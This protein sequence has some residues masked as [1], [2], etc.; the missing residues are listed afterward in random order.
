[1][2]TINRVF[3]IATIVLGIGTTASASANNSRIED[4]L[5]HVIV[6]QSQQV[7]ERLTEQLQHTINVELNNIVLNALPI[8][9]R[10]IS[11][12]QITNKQLVSK[13][14]L[15]NTSSIVNT[16]TEEE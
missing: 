15:T 2:K 11:T 1:M 8:I 14:Q 10:D 3:V 12:G 9:N 6:K 4:S 5:K 16:T 7:S 13:N